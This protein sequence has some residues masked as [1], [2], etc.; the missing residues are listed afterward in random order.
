QRSD[1]GPTNWVLRS[2]V[3]SFSTDLAAFTATNSSVFYTVLAPLGAGFSSLTTPVEFRIYGFSAGSINGTFRIDNVELDGTFNRGLVTILNDDCSI[4]TITSQPVGST[5]CAGASV[6][7]SV[8]A[9][10]VGTLTYQ[11]LKDGDPIT[12]ATANSFNIGSIL[13]SDAGSYSV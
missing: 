11:W 9:T 4:A 5:N 10:G 13:S 12:G 6:N 7:F 2:S 1:F 8:V 3:D